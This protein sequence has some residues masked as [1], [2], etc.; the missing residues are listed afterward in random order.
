MS[1]F[2]NTIDLLGDEAVTKALV[3]RTRMEFHDDVIT[4]VRRYAFYNNSQLTSIDLPSVT[5]I[6]EYAFR[7][8]SALTNVKLPS[9]ESTTAGGGSR[10]G[11][12]Q[13]CTALKSVTFPLLKSLSNQMFAYCSSLQIVDLYKVT[14]IPNGSITGC[15]ALKYLVL[16][17]ET[18]CAISSASALTGSP[19]DS[20]KTGGT[21]IVPASQVAGYTTH[22]NWSAILA[23]NAN[24]RV[25]ALE[26]YTVDGT[27]AGEIDWDKLGG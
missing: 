5:E 13:R 16:R 10:S 17:S 2:Q 22:T 11:Q 19:F 14:S 3:E 4:K 1:E 25:L 26:D 6:Y 24:N 20:G 7:E 8:C 15:G 23:Q 21:V 12:F 9:W 18:L 27:I